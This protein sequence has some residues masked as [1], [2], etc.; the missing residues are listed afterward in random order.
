MRGVCAESTER[1]AQLLLLLTNFGFHSVSLDNCRL[2]DQIF[3]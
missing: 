3:S 1:R 2:L